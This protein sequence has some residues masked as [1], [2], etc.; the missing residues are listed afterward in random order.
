ME[1]TE[2]WRQVRDRRKIQDIFEQI[3]SRNM[4]LKVNGVVRH[5]TK[6]PT[7]KYKDS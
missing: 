7:G 1:E 5:L 6:M 4:V 2:S 3:V